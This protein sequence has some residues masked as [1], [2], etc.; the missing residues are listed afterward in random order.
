MI[1]QRKQTESDAREDEALRLES[2][3][4]PKLSQAIVAVVTAVVG[5]VVIAA[6]VTPLDQVVAIP[7]KL[8]TR[9][10]TQAINIP[11]AGIVTEV[12]TE[13][14]ASV[15]AGQLLVVLDPS[16]KKGEVK[17]LTE[18]LQAESA[19]LNSEKRRINEQTQGLRLQLKIDEDILRPLEQLAQKGGIASLDVAEKRRILEA[20]RRE[21]RDSERSYET[22]VH[23]SDKLQSEIRLQLLSARKQL[24]QVRVKAPVI[25]TVLDLTAQTGQ[26]AQAN[27]TLLRIVPSEDLQAK[28]FAPSKDL[29]Y[30]RPG[31]SAK[32]ALSAYEATLYGY[33]QGSVVR[34][35][36]DALPKS[37][38][39]NYP[40][41]PITIEL[42]N[43]T[44]ERNGKRFALQPGMTLMAQI[45]LQ[46]RTLLQLLFSRFNRGLDAVRTMR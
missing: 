44:L 28:V 17:E 32:I 26:V 31:Q 46:Q 10:S 42:K 45:K 38:E 37:E 41:F 29:A 30:I 43:Q 22:L 14:G 23:E 20:T 8:V 15:K 7:G 4:E 19:R 27:T 5:T 34:V 6:A 16:L 40:N 18:K 3:P 35:S 13:E 36:E 33:L 39:Y 2:R 11:D 25:G 24:D 12:L 21:L 9:R 1:V